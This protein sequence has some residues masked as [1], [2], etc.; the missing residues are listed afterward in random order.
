MTSWRGPLIAM[1][2]VAA[3]TFGLA[4]VA[5]PRLLMGVAID[6]L[7]TGGLN[8]MSHGDLATPERQPVVRPSP[9]LA[10][11][12]CP[13]D[14]AH[15]PLL[16]DLAPVEGRYSSLS[17]FDGRTDVIFVRNDVQA[18]GRPYRVAIALPDQQVADGIEVVRTNEARGIALIRLLL[19]QP[20]ELAQ[21]QQ[22]RQKSSCRTLG[23]AGK[24]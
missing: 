14:L 21:L 24:K 3:L 13:F 12:A 1:L 5:M 20:G 17:V 23:A 19:K 11:S 7:S 10:Y 4:V 9:D 2:L 8:R 6:R 18:K 16:V 15:G 22:A